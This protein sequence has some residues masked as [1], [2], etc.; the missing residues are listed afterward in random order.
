MSQYCNCPCWKD[1]E[2]ILNC[3]KCNGNVYYAKV[4]KVH[5]EDENKIKLEKLKTELHDKRVDITILRMDIRELEQEIKEL[6]HV[7]VSSD[8]FDSS[9]SSSD[10]SDSSESSDSSDS[11]NVSFDDNSDVTLTE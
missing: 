2:L 9:D 8:S 1:K 3:H 7:P 6:E 11:Y 10:S 4:I 5:E